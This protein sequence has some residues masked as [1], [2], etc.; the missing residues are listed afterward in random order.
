MKYDRVRECSIISTVS[1]G[2]Q[3]KMPAPWIKDLRPRETAHLLKGDSRII[4]HPVDQFVWAHWVGKR[5]EGWP[6]GSRRL[7]HWVQ[8]VS[9]GWSKI[10]QQSRSPV[11]LRGWPSL[12]GGL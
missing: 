9:K 8:R 6:A 1:L 7:A 2:K 4:D 11:F 12:G 5:P 3:G 10:D